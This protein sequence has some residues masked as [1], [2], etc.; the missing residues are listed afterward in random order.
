MRFIDEVTIEVL[1]GNGGA[2]CVS[3]RREKYIPK[4]GP[5]GGNGGRG[6]HVHLRASHDRNTLQEL[7]LK[8]RIIAANGQPGMG[9][10]KG[11]SNGADIEVLVPEGTIIRDEYGNLLADLRHDG[12]DFAVASGGKGGLGNSN[13]A[14]SVNQAPRYAQPGLEGEQQVISLELSLMADIGLVGLPN[15]G[16]STLISH[17]SNAHPKI[18][19]YPF[20]TLAPSL[21]Q[22]SLPEGDGF[23]VAD[24]PGLIAGA[25][26]GKGLGDRFLRHIRRTRMLLHLVDAIDTEGRSVQEQ[27]T[28]VSGELAGYS[29]ELLAKPRWLV[30]NKMDALDLDDRA[31]I[32]A[33]VAAIDLPT[34]FISA[35]SGEGIKPML[36][37]LAAALRGDDD[38]EW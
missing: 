27:F 3:F 24:I 26:E 34:Y 1:A 38:S 28:E 5:D 36:F 25:H 4:G 31:A 13:Y 16:K 21:G 12:D 37:A 9:R 11:G 33:Q 7:Y 2:G 23:V 6:G 8:K 15:A 32:E 30:V 18:A 19:D 17:I 14:T 20:T 29:D 35:A 22:V 10:K